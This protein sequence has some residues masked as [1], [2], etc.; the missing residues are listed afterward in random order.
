MHVNK[1]IKLT[2]V[3]FER[4]KEGVYAHKGKVLFMAYE[5]IESFGDGHIDLDNGNTLLVEEDAETILA[6]LDKKR[7]EVATMEKMTRAEDR[8]GMDA[9]DIENAD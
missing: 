7:A 3:D 2:M 5:K 9:E 8:L 1:E 6:L 4:T